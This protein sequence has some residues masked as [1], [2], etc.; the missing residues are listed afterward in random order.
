MSEFD[1]SEHPH[2]RYNP[3]SGE[4]V[5]V[6]PHRTKRPWQGQV[7]KAASETR[8]SYDPQCYLCPR[9]SRADGSQNPDYADTFV[10][11]NDF[12]ALLP[13]TPAGESNHD[14]LLITEAERGLCRVICFSPRHDLTLPET[15]IG[16]RIVCDNEH[17]VALVPFWAT[18]PFETLVLC[19]RRVASLSELTEDEKNTLADI[20]GA[21][22][23]R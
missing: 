7:E 17:F 12:S 2:R 20:L 3:L 21:A 10:F 8:P 1:V 19:R 16:E 22:P 13:D 6:S 18:W 11:Q 9:N 4:W 23:P 5:L 15:E 14:D